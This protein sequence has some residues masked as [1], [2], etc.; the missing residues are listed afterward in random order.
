[1]DAKRVSPDE[2]LLKVSATYVQQVEELRRVNEHLKAEN[3]K[4]EADVRRLQIENT[5][6]TVGSGEAKTPQ[7]II[8]LGD[9]VSIQGRVSGVVTGIDLEAKQINVKWNWPLEQAIKPGPTPDYEAAGKF[10]VGDK[11]RHRYHP[12][13]SCGVVTKV[14]DS[15]RPF[16]VNWD[17]LSGF[18]SKRE[19]SFDLELAPEHSSIGA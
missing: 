16:T 3:A 7:P 14:H 15:E 13:Y 9:P 8:R 17:L 11:V 19:W 2:A 12:D 4:L 18:C 10:K 6:F 5:Q 1:M